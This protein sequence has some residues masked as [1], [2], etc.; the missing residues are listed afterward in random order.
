M[1]TPHYR[2][3]I[4]LQPHGQTPAARTEQTQ[5]RRE[6]ALDFVTSM[7]EW[8]SEKDLGTKVSNL[9]VTLFGQVQI[10][11]DP[12]VINLIRSQDVVGIAAIRQGNT[13]YT[14][15]MNR[16]NEAG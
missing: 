6:M 13:A 11:C 3:F 12:D 7:K 2:Y 10:T 4:E 5:V 1:E 16:W 15:V 14:D 8:L 9:G